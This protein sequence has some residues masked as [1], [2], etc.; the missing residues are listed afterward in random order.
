MS[1]YNPCDLNARADLKASLYAAT[2]EVAKAEEQY[3]TVLAVDAR[4]PAALWALV[5]V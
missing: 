5:S 2:S 4:N 1:S 3:R